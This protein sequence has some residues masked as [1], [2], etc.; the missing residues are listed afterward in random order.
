MRRL[1]D[2][3]VIYGRHVVSSDKDVAQRMELGRM[4]AP[5]SDLNTD[6]REQTKRRKTAG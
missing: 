6:K 4:W 2:N 1:P 5:I 3:A